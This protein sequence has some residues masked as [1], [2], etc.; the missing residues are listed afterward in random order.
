MLGTQGVCTGGRLVSD[1]NK[2]QDRLHDQCWLEQ[3]RQPDSALLRKGSGLSLQGWIAS[4]AG[5]T[6]VYFLN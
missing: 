6:H 2:P 3:S 1:N 5:Y 4:Q